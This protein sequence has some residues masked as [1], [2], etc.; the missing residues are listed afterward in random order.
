MYNQAE[1][2]VLNAATHQNQGNNEG[3]LPCHDGR[4]S[5]CGL[6]QDADA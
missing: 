1:G 5:T 6:G 3:S 2:A 4:L